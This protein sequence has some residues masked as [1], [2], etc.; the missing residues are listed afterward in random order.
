MG[1][2]L[3]EDAE[4][5]IPSEGEWDHLHSAGVYCLELSRPADPDAAWGEYHDTEPDWWPAFRDAGSV[6]YVGS[7]KDVLERLED[8][9]DGQRDP[10]T[11]RKPVL[12]D[13]CTIDFLRNI[14]WCDADRRKVVEA[15]TASLL[16]N[17]YPDV[18]V[19]QA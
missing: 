7:A 17:E 18:F 11:P 16:R 4:P 6:W 5:F 15:N 1:L 2:S 8:H 12:M 14:W 13:I 19:R 10:D 3:P 9:R